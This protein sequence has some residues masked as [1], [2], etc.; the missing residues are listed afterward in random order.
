MGPGSQRRPRWC[1]TAS[2]IEHRIAAV[3]R[4]QG[5][6]TARPQ[7]P[8]R[9]QD[10]F[11]TPPQAKAVLGGRRRDGARYIMRCERVIPRSPM[12]DE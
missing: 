3:G 4:V 2:R 11:S 6:E 5:L 7:C 8:D 12:L 9:R 1:S 10:A